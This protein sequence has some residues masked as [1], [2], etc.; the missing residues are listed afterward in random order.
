[1]ELTADLQS[2]L[3]RC[4]SLV[5]L[6]G[7]GVSAESGIPTFRGAG[8]LWKQYR[9]QDLATPEAFSRSPEVV[10]EWYDMRRSLIAAARPNPAHQALVDLEALFPSFLLITQNID[11][12]HRRAG[13]QALLEIHGNIWKARCT[14][15]AHVFDELRNPLPFPELPRCSLC[16]QLARPHVVWFG[17][18]YDAQIIER[19]EDSLSH[20]ELLLV[21][22][23]SGMVS[24]PVFL[25]RMARDRGALVLECNLETSE[26]SSLADFSFSGP[27]GETLP[28]LVQFF[29][30]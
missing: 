19:A 6:T 24:M 18:S 16:G 21:C 1:M 14:V 29:R 30:E 3:K 25:T 11:G 26:I 23:T 5:V 8:G 20:C 15:C 9:P 10:W 17:E 13:T 28:Q 2:R 27:A 12:L 22:G 4:R 7:A